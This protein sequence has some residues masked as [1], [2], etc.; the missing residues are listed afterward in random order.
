[1]GESVKEAL[2]INGYGLNCC[3]PVENAKALLHECLGHAGREWQAVSDP[4]LLPIVC[5]QECQKGPIKKAQFGL[6]KNQAV[7]DPI[8][9]TDFG[10]IRGRT[11]SSSPTNLLNLKGT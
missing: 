8:T 5:H 4:P 6:Q 3:L 2:E 9:N 11:A 7:H 10:I 1:M